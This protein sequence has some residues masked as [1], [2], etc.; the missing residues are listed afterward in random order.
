MSK[1]PTT[2]MLVMPNFL[3]LPR[4]LRDIVYFY[5]FNPSGYVKAYKSLFANCTIDFLRGPPACAYPRPY[6]AR[7]TPTILLLNR[8]IT[9]EALIVLYK[10]PLILKGTPHTYFTMR[11]MDITEFIS[12]RLLQRIHFAELRLNQAHKD[13]ILPLLDIWGSENRLERL[14]VYIKRT[15]RVENNRHWMIVESRVGVLQE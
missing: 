12:E 5:S 11:Q 4:E 7:Y 2:C 10:K 9:S 6:V 14:D 3:D 1:Y 8:Q 13:F 15:E